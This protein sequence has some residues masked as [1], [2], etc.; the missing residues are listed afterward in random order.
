MFFIETIEEKNASPALQQLYDKNKA[1]LG[2]I[3]NYTRLFSHSPDVMVAW[4]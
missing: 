2:Y 3:A 4:I 1:T